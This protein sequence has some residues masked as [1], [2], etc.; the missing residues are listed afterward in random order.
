MALIDIIIVAIFFLIII[1]IGFIERKKITLEDYWVN[2]RKTKTFFLV[3]TV[4]STF[5]GVGAILGTAGIAF[6]GGGLIALAIPFSFLFYLMLYAKFIAP[7]IK[8]FGDK[9]KA[10]T[11]PDFF[12]VKY[13][14]GAGI[15]ASFVNLIS[16]GLYLAL[17]IVGMGIFVNVLTGFSPIIATIVGALVVITYTTVGGLRADI[18]TDVFQFVM[19]ILLLTMFLPIVIFKGGGFSA[20]QSLPSSFLLGTDFAPPYVIILAFLFIGIAT[21]TYADLWQRAYAG[22][23]KKTVKKAAYISGILAFLFLVMAVL[24]GVYGHI[25]LPNSTSNTVLA[26]LMTLILPVGLYGLVLAGFFAAVMSSADTVLLITSMTLVHDIY[27][28]G[29]NK[30]M[31]EEE[32]LKLSRRVTFILGIIA[33]IVALII[34][35]IVHLAIEAISFYVVLTPSIIFGFY[36][37]RANTKA[38][39]WSIII[40]LIGVTAFL[41]IDPVQAFIP[42]IVLSFITYVLVAFLTKRKEINPN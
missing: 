35:N 6:N 21:F 24:L 7:K 25:L 26:D 37:K 15:L 3:A 33:L 34:F 16:Y 39:V 42:G 1:I 19:M 30:Q 22:E 36:W 29:M 12:A 18:R 14:K 17:Q 8:E 4:L 23:S 2:S 41:F 10:Y 9:H 13:S 5:I 11:L 32:T 38:A 20:L 28:K 31:S 40:G 27:R